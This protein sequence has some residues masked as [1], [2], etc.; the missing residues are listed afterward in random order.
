MRFG[1]G[2]VKT[3]RAN[4]SAPNDICPSFRVAAQSGRLSSPLSLSFS[5]Y[6]SRTQ[7][8]SYP[9]TRYVYIIYYVLSNTHAHC[10]HEGVNGGDRRAFNIARVENYDPAPAFTLVFEVRSPV[11]RLI[12][13]RRW[14]TVHDFAKG[15]SDTATTTIYHIPT[16]RYTYVYIYIY[17]LERFLINS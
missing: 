10:A 13:R 5:L 16:S 11:F 9:Y 15:L 8:S 4:T 6:L 3:K 2:P 12:Y 7:S 14:S 17:T 1:L